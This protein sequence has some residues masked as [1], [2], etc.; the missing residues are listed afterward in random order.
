MTMPAKQVARWFLL[1]TRTNGTWGSRLVAACT[2][3]EELVP[4]DN[5]LL[6]DRVVVTAINRAGVASGAVRLSL[7]P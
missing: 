7:A 4:N 2:C 5:G 1:Q 3:D 6:P